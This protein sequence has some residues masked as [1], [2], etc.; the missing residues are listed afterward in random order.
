MKQKY[1]IMFYKDTSNI[2]DDIQTFAA[3]RF[4]PHIDYVIEREALDS[5][6]S[7]D[8]EKVK[9][10]MNG[11]YFHKAE[12]WP[13]TPFLYPKLISMHFTD[14]LMIDGW[15]PKCDWRYMLGEMDPS[16]LKQYGPVGCRDQHTMEMFTSLKIPA[17]F[18]SCL[19][20]TIDLKKEKK[21]ENVIYAVDV[22]DEIVDFIKAHTKS[23]VVVLTHIMAKK[24]QG[25]N[26]EERMQAVE[27]L[28]TK[29]HNAKMVVT[30]RLHATL[31]CLA[32]KTPVLLIRHDDPLYP[33]RLE[34]F[35]DLVHS[36][37]EQDLLDGTYAYD[38]DKPKTN[39]KKYL[40]YRKKLIKECED[41]INNTED[42]GVVSD[43]EYIHWLEK[44]KEFQKQM[45]VSTTLKSYQEA[46]ESKSE[47]EN[48][49]K[50]IEKLN[51]ELNRIY[52]SRS[53]QWTQKALKMI[54]KGKK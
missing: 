40:S 15:G 6:V 19:T 13:P 25:K 2:G 43:K 24:E 21:K 17:Y 16:F 54:G 22:R 31:P 14:N 18:S 36:T 45:L 12:N 26:F 30:S 7:K 47:C 52:Y 8:Y 4:L 50:E 34:T 42:C 35:Y 38:F 53:Y 39:P 41:F 1:G 32:L 37:E 33:G 3:K 51:E 5:F 28:L 23:K 46:E 44:T 9:V 29:Y 20:T 48:K 11:W 49:K 10:I 27:E